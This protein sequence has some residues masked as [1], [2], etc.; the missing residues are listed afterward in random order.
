MSQPLEKLLKVKKLLKAAKKLPA[1]GQGENLVTM[2]LAASTKL[3]GAA[4]AKVMLL[5]FSDPKIGLNDQTGMR[6]FK[7]SLALLAPAQSKTIAKIPEVSGLTPGE[8]AEWLDKLQRGSRAKSEPLRGVPAIYVKPQ[9][10]EIRE[11][12]ANVLGKAFAEKASDRLVQ[13]ISIRMTAGTRESAAT[14]VQAMVMEFGMPQEPPPTSGDFD[15]LRES[16]HQALGAKIERVSFFRERF[17]KW[18]AP[19]RADWEKKLVAGASSWSTTGAQRESATDLG[20]ASDVCWLNDSM[21]A[22]GAPKDCAAMAEDP[23]VTRIGIPRMLERELDVTGVTVGAA[24]FR[25][26]TGFAGKG[27]LVAVIDGEVDAT[28]PALAGRVL[29]KKNFTGE[30]W[31]SPDHHGTGVAGII[32]SSQN[33]LKGMAPGVDIASYKVFATNQAAQGTDFDATLA[34]Q[35]ALEDGVRIANCSWGVG[36]ATDGTSR[37]ARAFDRA[38]DLGMILVKSAGNNGPGAGTMTSPADAR[39]VIVVGA[40]NRKGKL[41]EAY[42]SRGPVP[43]KPGPDV[44]TP[45]GSFGDG[46]RSLTVGG[47]TGDIGRGTSFAAPHVV[48]LA[49]LLLQQNPNATPDQIKAMLIANASP[50]AGNTVAGCGAGLVK[51]KA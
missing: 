27:I 24:A 46:I 3:T 43:A 8:I 12:C 5:P 41:L 6:A 45:G 38:W 49:A 9:S 34:V 33:K 36:P 17:Y 48:G 25:L 14:Q 23:S 28:H 29:Q 19:L 20:S 44:L 26:K 39:G 13:A 40:T 22:V 30:A 15:H 31:G 21:R 51:L 16:L 42:S 11:K 4:A 18:I 47:G 7:Q 1:P 37:E 35:Q 2:A 50:I 10:A 32:A